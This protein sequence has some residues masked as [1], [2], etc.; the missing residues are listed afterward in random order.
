[1]R[2]G[3]DL[4]FNNYESW[5]FVRLRGSK[6]GWCRCKAASAFSALL[7]ENIKA[8]TMPTEMTKDLNIISAKVLKLASNLM[9]S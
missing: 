3:H 9:K 6:A 4:F 7:A 8:G 1:M 2:V 5:V